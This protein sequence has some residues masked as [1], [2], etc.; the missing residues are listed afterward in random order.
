MSDFAVNAQADMSAWKVLEGLVQSP[1]ME[2]FKTPPK[3]QLRDQIDMD[4]FDFDDDYTDD[5]QGLM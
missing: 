4:R 2:K 5:N 1:L 3:Q